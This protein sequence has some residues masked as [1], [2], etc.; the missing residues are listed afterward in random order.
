M[1]AAKLRVNRLTSVI[2]LLSLRERIKVRVIQGAELIVQKRACAGLPMLITPALVPPTTNT[3][4]RVSRTCNEMVV[5]HTD[6]LHQC[7]TDR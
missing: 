5:N 4:L 7:V 3:E 6:R 2:A 1:V